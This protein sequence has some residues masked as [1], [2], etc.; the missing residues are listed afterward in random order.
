[1]DIMIIQI[2]MIAS[3]IKSLM[4]ASYMS[5]LR[6]AS[7]GLAALDRCSIVAYEFAFNGQALEC[8]GLK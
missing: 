4:S 7:S 5:W 2:V 6:A 1:M 8:L 3:S